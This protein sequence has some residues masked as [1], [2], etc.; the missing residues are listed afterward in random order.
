MVFR[1]LDWYLQCRALLLKGQG[2]TW[3]LATHRAGPIRR[4]TSLTVLGLD[5]PAVSGQVFPLLGY[6]LLGE[7]GGWQDLSWVSGHS[8]V[9]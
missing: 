8:S 7:A 6:L 5:W 1:K 9:F 2:W 3:L 4:D